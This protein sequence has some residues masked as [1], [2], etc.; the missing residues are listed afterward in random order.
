M[1]NLSDLAADLKPFILRWIGGDSTTNSAGVVLSP[2]QYPDALLRDGTRSLLGNM[3]VGSGVTIDGVDIDVFKADTL[4]WQSGHLAASDPHTQYAFD[5]T[6]MVAGAGLTG[7]GTLGADRTFHVGAGTGI[8]VNA[9]DVAVN[10]GYAFNWSA[11]HIFSAG[12][13]IDLAQVV[14]FGANVAGKETNAG[15][16]GYGA[17][18]T[19][20][21][22]IVGAGTSVRHV[23]LWDNTW[24]PGYIGS[25]TYTSQTTGWRIDSA[26]AADLRYLFVDEM[27]AKSFIADLEQALAG[28]QIISKSVAMLGKAFTAPAAGSTTTLWVRDLPSAPGMAAFQSGDIVRV[29]T[30]ARASG[31]LSISDCWGVV[32]SYADGSGADEGLQSWTFTRSSGGNAGAMTAGTTVNVDSIVLDYGTS[33]NG[34]WETNAIDG[35]YGANSPYTQAVQ[36]TT[37]PATGSVVRYRAGK[38]DG[39]S[40]SYTGTNT[41]GFA[42]GNSAATWVAAEATN[43][44]RVMYGSVAKGQW[45]TSGNLIIGEVGSGKNNVYINNAGIISVRSNTATVITLSPNTATVGP[46]SLNTVAD[47]QGGVYASALSSAAIYY[48]SIEASKYARTFTGSNSAATFETG[49]HAMYWRNHMLAGSP[50]TLARMYSDS[51]VE[52]GGTLQRGGYFVIEGL[53]VAYYNNATSSYTGN[54]V[55]KIVLKSSSEIRLDGPVQGTGNIAAA[56][57]VYASNW[58]RSNGATGWYSETYG[59]GW[60]MQDTTFIRSFGNKHVYINQGLLVDIPIATQVRRTSTQSIANGTWTA[61]TFSDTVS[62][63]WGRWDAGTAL[64][65][66]YTGYYWVSVRGTWAANSTGVRMIAIAKNGAEYVDTQ[67]TA[68]VNGFDHHQSCTHLVYLTAGDYVQMHVYQ[69]SGGALNIGGTAT[70]SYCRMSI[71]KAT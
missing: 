20:A 3:A 32:T 56:G 58:F 15:K 13:K 57:A 44:F 63:P 60:W 9:D 54:A 25:Q 48:T 70:S 71:H 38:L 29:R 18:T 51:Y 64:Y 31:S 46:Y 24:I 52:T 45:D 5:V 30:F 33:G 42:A 66:N 1:I 23:K 4:A 11:S 6:Q 41:F 21:L 28:G 26:G 7:G 65:A 47:F 40:A 50:A 43:G 59:G 10:T 19:G 37:H 2:S 55:T 69:S 14:E 16:I 61:I 68:A 36:W 22:D 27:H 8:T 17:F 49:Q 39:W 34:I 35:V 12:A 67:E 62:D 53:D